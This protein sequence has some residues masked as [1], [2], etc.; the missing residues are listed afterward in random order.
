MYCSCL[1]FEFA[2]RPDRIDGCMTM[3]G[4]LLF[5]ESWIKVGAGLVFR[6]GKET[7][8]CPKKWINNNNKML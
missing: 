5:L 3:S 4:L 2:V 6:K 1:N 7:L 8:A